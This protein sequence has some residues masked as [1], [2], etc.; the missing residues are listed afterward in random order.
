MG[1]PRKQLRDI[2]EVDRFSAPH[3]RLH[4]ASAGGIDATAAAAAAAA[5]Y[6]NQFYD[7]Q[8]SLYGVDKRALAGRPAY[9][10]YDQIYS[11]FS[12]NQQQ[13]AGMK[14]FAFPTAYTATAAPHPSSY[15]SQQN[16]IYASY[17]RQLQYAREYRAAGVR[18]GSFT[19][20]SESDCSASDH[21]EVEC[22]DK[23][24][25]I[26]TADHTTTVSP[27]LTQPCIPSSQNNIFLNKHL[28]SIQSMHPALCRSRSP[29]PV[30]MS[31]SKN[32][33]TK[34]ADNPRPAPECKSFFD[35]SRAFP[36]SYWLAAETPDTTT[37]R[38]TQ[39]QK[40]TTEQIVL[41]YL[42]FVGDLC[43]GNDDTA[44]ISSESSTDSN[45]SKVIITNANK[46]ISG[47]NPY[48]CNNT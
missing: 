16:Q 2:H 10:P 47:I 38:W 8:H 22:L 48:A 24:A 18:S 13:L 45:T 42:G 21:S 15:L 11:W 17:Y 30:D 33:S 14:Q 26:V 44:S 29:Q 32:N 34:K 36:S 1:R 3:P 7:S 9:H 43:G 28:H 23:S 46:F 5:A 35:L 4:M 31:T 27:R 39:D 41:S 6:R 19:S 37:A 12:R 40:T 20:G 25:V